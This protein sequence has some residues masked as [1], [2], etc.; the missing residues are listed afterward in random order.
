LF[1]V[2]YSSIYI[3]PLNSHRQTEALLVRLY[4]SYMIMSGCF[5]VTFSDLPDKT[6]R[7][8]TVRGVLKKLPPPNFAVLKFIITH[9]NRSVNKSYD[10]V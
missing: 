1:F 10:L 7:L 4:F 6:L 2:L 9:I 3:A 8:L 5:L